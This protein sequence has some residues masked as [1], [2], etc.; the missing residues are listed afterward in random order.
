LIGLWHGITWNFLIWGAW[1]GLG[2]FLHNRWLDFSRSHWS[3]WAPPGWIKTG[4]MYLGTF[5]TFNYVSLGWVWFALPEPAQSLATIQK[6]FG[7]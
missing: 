7:L 4:L 2:L 1:H 6:L 5:L 3:E